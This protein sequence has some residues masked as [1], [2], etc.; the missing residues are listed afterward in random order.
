[1][2][3]KEMIHLVVL[4]PYMQLVLK[5][6]NTLE[7]LEMTDIKC[8]SVK[9]FQGQEKKVIIIST[10]RSTIKHNE[11]DRTYFL[12][13]LSNPSRFNVAVTRAISLLVI[14]GNPHIIN[15]PLNPQLMPA[16]SQC[17]LPLKKLH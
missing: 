2:R 12:G 1:M 3:G 15:R 14:I 16:A 9:Q 17:L 4:T 10:V 6:K 5:L 7:S 8:G 13:F 11:F